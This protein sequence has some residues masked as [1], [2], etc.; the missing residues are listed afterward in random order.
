[1]S[2][3]LTVEISLGLN[4]RKFVDTVPPVPSYRDR[5]E[6]KRTSSRVLESYP[7][8]SSKLEQPANST[9]NFSVRRSTA[10]KHFCRIAV[11]ALFV[12]TFAQSQ[13]FAQYTGNP[14]IYNSGRDQYLA[15]YGISG[16]ISSNCDTISDYN[17]QQMCYALS[18]NSQ[19][20]CTSMTDRNLQLACYGMAMR[21]NSPTYP[22]N[23]DD[24]TDTYLRSFCYAVSTPSSSY[25]GNLI[26]GNTQL[27]CLAMSTSTPSYCN[28]INNPNDR[29]FCY[30]V[31]SRNN[32]Y[33]A[34]I[35][36]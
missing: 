7:C 26:D 20:P 11:F 34:N 18:E 6:A 23:C 13:A 3:E 15:C 33:C 19:A 22:T 14:F 21:F 10:M 2:Q 5:K 24:I 29:Y 12:A 30:G 9:L 28:N 35:I 1:M 17:D 25:C 32:S 27:L 31:S 36:Q 16:N 4:F 8:M